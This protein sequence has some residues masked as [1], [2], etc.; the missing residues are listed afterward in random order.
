[1]SR[2]E[3]VRQATAFVDL[4]RAKNPIPDFGE[5][6]P[7]ASVEAGVPGCLPCVI[8]LLDD[9]RELLFAHREVARVQPHERLV[10]W[11]GPAEYAPM[12]ARPF[13]GRGWLDRM[14]LAL[15]AACECTIADLLKLASVEAR[16]AAAE[17]GPL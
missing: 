10:V 8:T 5:R 2:A 4:F 12:F 1:M 11:L 17:L 9:H 16:A 6:R 14:V 15:T 3:N 7:W 13:R